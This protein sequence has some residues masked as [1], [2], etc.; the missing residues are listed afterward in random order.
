MPQ[1][2][3]ALPNFFPCSLETDVSEETEKR[4]QDSRWSGRAVGGQG[5]EVQSLAQDGPPERE[6]EQEAKDS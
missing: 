5:G 1:T 4:T 3:P 2:A 6:E